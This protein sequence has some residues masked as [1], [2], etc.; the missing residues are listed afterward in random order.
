MSNKDLD[1]RTFSIASV[2][3]RLDAARQKPWFQQVLRNEVTSKG[4]GIPSGNEADG[5]TQTGQ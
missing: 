4:S 5:R 2:P 3:F 1:P